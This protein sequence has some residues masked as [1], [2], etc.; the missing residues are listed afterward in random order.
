MISRII[1]FFERGVWMVRSHEMPFCKRVI[2]NTTRVLMLTGRFFVEN[3]CTVKAS[4]L[5]YYTLFSIVPILALAFGIAK[6]Y[7]YAEFLEQKL[8]ETMEAYP[9]LAEN[10]ITFADN[11]LQKTKGGLIAGVGVL[12]LIWTAVKLLS[13]IE[14]TMNGIWGVK[15][16]RTLL[17][18]VTDYITILLFC[19]M[20]MLAAWSGI[21]FATTQLGGLTKA[22][23]FPRH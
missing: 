9:D 12:L 10:I 6:G 4:A 18:K 20:L 3:Q 21:V 15:R 16:G 22:L 23:P 1:N 11:L 19:P 7:G 2:L 17:R 13:N 5:T 14:M 8:R